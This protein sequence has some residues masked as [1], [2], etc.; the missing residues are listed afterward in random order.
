M[1]NLKQCSCGAPMEVI[2]SRVRK[3]G[4]IR[5]RRE[6]SNCGDRF[7]TIEVPQVQY[8]RMQRKV[9]SFDRIRKLVRGVVPLNLE[10]D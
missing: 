4:G 1:T 2:D 9:L 10:E 3:D 6:C 8:K 5:R 7:T